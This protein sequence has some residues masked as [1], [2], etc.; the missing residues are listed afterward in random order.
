MATVLVISDLHAPYNHESALD[1][2]GDLNREYKPERTVCIGDEADYCRWSR[3]EQSADMPGPRE[4]LDAARKVLADLAKIFPALDICVSNHGVRITKRATEAGIP[5]SA[6]KNPRDILGAPHGW[7]W[8][9]YWTIDG[10]NYRHGDGFSGKSAALSAAERLRRNVVIGHVHSSAGVWYSA[11]HFDTV[12][13]MGVGCLVN[14][15]HS[16]FA[17]GKWLAARPVLGAGL[18]FDGVPV[19]VP[20]HR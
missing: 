20:L 9:D 8:K 3:H 2:L 4:E 19:F 1:F 7:V 10:V 15:D 11:G 13:G 12:W 5:A 18:V 17:Y 6:I 16:A 14:P